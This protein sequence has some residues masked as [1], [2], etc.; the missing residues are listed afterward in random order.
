MVNQ[1]LGRRESAVV[2]AKPAKVGIAVAVAVAV[3]VMVGA[4]AAGFLVT[5]KTR[6]AASPSYVV[7]EPPEP[8]RP[9]PAPEKPK[10]GV[11]M[12][13]ANFY[14]LD[15]YVSPVGIDANGDGVEDVAAAFILVEHGVLN[16]Y[17]GVVDGK[18]WEIVWKDGPYGDREKAR[19]STGLAVQGGRLMAVNVLGDAHIFDLKT[20]EKLSTFQF[21]AEDAARWICATPGGVYFGNTWSTGQR[22]DLKTLKRTKVSAPKECRGEQRRTMDTGDLSKKQALNET[23]AAPKIERFDGKSW[24]HDGKRGVMLGAA[25][26]S[27]LI[28]LIGFDPTK[29]TEVWRKALAELVPAAVEGKPQAIDLVGGVFF[30]AYGHDGDHHVVAIDAATGEKKWDSVSPGSRFVNVTVA[31]QR[32]YLVTH[33][34]D[35]M[36]VNVFDLQSGTLVARLGGSGSRFRPDGD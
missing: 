3:L 2:P 9:P 11:P 35:A 20:G 10:P 5:K 22:V 7:V 19:R 36:P 17:V 4:G 28:E 15:Q 24:F 8:P 32:L 16:A 26:G 25:R 33:E 27:E 29:R 23:Q 30:L 12:G 34:W 31:A 13:P 18:T 14:W 21:D 1:L 6:P